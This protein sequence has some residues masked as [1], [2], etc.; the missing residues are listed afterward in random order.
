M[1]HGLL[2]RRVQ[3]GS[4]AEDDI[5]IVELH[6]AE[7]SLRAFDEVL[8]ADTL[9]VGVRLL[10]RIGAYAELGSDDEVFAAPDTPFE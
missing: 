3:L 9:S 8:A 7:R 5:D 6:A 10:N 2:D 4:V 1:A